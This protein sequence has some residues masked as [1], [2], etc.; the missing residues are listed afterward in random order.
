MTTPITFTPEEDKAYGEF[1]FHHT[2]RL[3]VRPIP[4]RVFHYTSGQGLIGILESGTL[5]ATQIACMNDAKELTHSADELNKV[6]DERRAAGKL[7][8]DADFI[9]TKM[10]KQL[11]DS[12]AETSGA[13]IACFT[14]QED[15]LSQWRAYGGGEGGY[16]IE[17]DAQ[18]IF[19]IIPAIGFFV[20][21]NYIRADQDVVFDDVLKWTEAFFLQGLKT[22]PDREQ[23]AE[24]FSARW[25][26][27]ISFLAP[28]IK[29]PTFGAE[30]EWRIIYT[31]KDADFSRLSFIQKQSLMSRYI[32]LQVGDQKSATGHTLLPITRVIVGPMRHKEVSRISVGDLLKARGYNDVKVEVTK[33]PYRLA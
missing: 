31:L 8:A 2:K 30:K 17:F 1:V 4:A 23:W 12:G 33:V 9:L 16:A 25:L 24:A 32:P 13:F 21:V 22:R 19:R 5:R 6:I 14:E 26:A 10:Q 28:L 29:H 11:L 15:D 20:P 3:I 7:G 18:A 27:T